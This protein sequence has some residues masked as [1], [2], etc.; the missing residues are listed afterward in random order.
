MNLKSPLVSVVTPAFNAQATISATI[1]SVL[2]QTYSN[3]ELIIVDDGST[4]ETKK[5]VLHKNDNRIN[6]IYQVNQERAIARNNGISYSRGDYIAFLDSDDLWLPEKLEKQI[7]L[8]EK[9]QEISLVYSDLYF[10]DDIT[11]NDII[12]FSKIEKLYRG[13]IKIKQ[14]LLHNFI[15]S[16]TPVIKRQV[17]HEVGLFN[18]N[19]VPVE[20]WEM[21]IK[22][23][24]LF[25]IDYVDEPLARYRLHQNALF[26]FNTPLKLFEGI[27][28]VLD[29]I[30]D[31]K[32]F[33]G[34]I[35]KGAIRECRS[36]ACYNYGLSMMRKNKW[37]EA[38]QYL[39]QAI[40][41]HPIN[42]KIYI[43]YIQML[44]RHV[45]PDDILI[46][47]E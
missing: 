33:Q 11:G 45:N 8:F 6:Y 5:I 18:P 31:Q 22:I 43:R 4:D 3:L 26:W 20:D 24:S 36:L 27:N 42:L 34:Q 13:K 9:N 38:S 23:A 39:I 35:T 14:L 32:I 41:F 7:R 12:L 28:N 19:M 1:D 16:P 37:N 15:Q 46:M 2:N 30:E 21:W 47:R 25:P 44:M 10:F 29:K 40:K 17:F